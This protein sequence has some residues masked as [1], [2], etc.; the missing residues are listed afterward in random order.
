[1]KRLFKSIKK[2]WNEYCFFCFY[3]NQNF[4][5]EGL[6]YRVKATWWGFIKAEIHD[7]LINPN[8]FKALLC[9]WTGKH[10]YE[11]ESG[12]DAESGPITYFWCTR[13]GHSGRNFGM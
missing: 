5:D 8:A 9:K 1:M 10:N 12:G 3:K 2:E 4:A 13:C 11:M 7:F 6:K